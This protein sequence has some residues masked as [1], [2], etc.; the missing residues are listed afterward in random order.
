MAEH[1]IDQNVITVARK[2]RP[3]SLYGIKQ[4]IE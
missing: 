4:D 2:E 3:G 1:F